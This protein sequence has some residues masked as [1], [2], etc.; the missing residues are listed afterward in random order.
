MKPS[1]KIKQTSPYPL[2]QSE[3]L[4]QMLADIAMGDKKSKRASPASL[5]ESIKR[6]QT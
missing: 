4:Q 1:R 2:A 5:M 6:L 3:I